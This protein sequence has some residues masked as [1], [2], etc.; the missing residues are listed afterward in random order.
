MLLKKI[1]FKKLFGMY[2]HEVKLFKDG[3]SIVIGKNGIG[4]TYILDTINAFFNKQFYFFRELDYEKISFIFED[5]VQWDINNIE[6]DEDSFLRIVS[7]END[8]TIKIP[9][10]E[11][12]NLSSIDLRRKA[13]LIY[14]N[15]PHIERINPRL[16][17]DT[18]ENKHLDNYELVAKYHESLELDE[19]RLKE[20][21]GKNVPTFYERLEK[22]SVY[23]IGAHR[24]YNFR[25]NELRRG[26]HEENYETQSIEKIQDYAAELKVQIQDVETSY[27][28]VAAN[29]DESFPY[30]LIQLIREGNRIEENGDSVN[31]EIIEQISK[32]LLELDER[33]NSLKEINL[34]PNEDVES[35]NKEDIKLAEEAINLYIKDSNEKFDIYENLR[36]KITLFLDI[37]NNRFNYK[38]IAIDKNRGFKFI[39]NI[40][41]QNSKEIPMNKLSSGEKNE[42][43]L[44][45]ELI[46]KSRE[47]NLVLI[48]EPEI[49]LHI[50]WQNLFV[51]DLKRVHELTDIRVLMATHS[52][53]IINTNWDLTNELS[54]VGNYAE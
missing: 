25:S 19:K 45:F 2:D 46:F 53:D 13:N 21:L 40:S 16:F 34:L 30:R 29:L 5:N 51:E 3:I 44:F 49:S 54:G 24:I 48:D 36:E 52:P 41:D 43:I 27:S 17:Y 28:K 39:Q 9:F 4:K 32:K 33:R 37:I 23:L 42:F 47:E 22:N 1:E 26:F 12:I 31:E 35:I 11:L 10:D 20:I 18:E 38:K 6:N 8:E 7:T 50:S 15:V 14:R